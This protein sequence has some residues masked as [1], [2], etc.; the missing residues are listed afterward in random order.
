MC[1][2]SSPIHCNYLRLFLLC[3]CDR[4]APPCLW[5]ISSSPPHSCR[6][7]SQ[8]GNQDSCLF[9]C[10]RLSHSGQSSYISLLYSALGLS[11]TPKKC[12]VTSVNTEFGQWLPMFLMEDWE[13]NRQILWSCNFL[14]LCRKP[15]WKIVRSLKGLIY[16]ERW[17]LWYLLLWDRAISL[18]FCG[19]DQK[20]HPGPE[21]IFPTKVF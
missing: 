18:S 12:R 13:I 17:S 9:S 2:F 7:L 16:E 21:K 11:K 5:S 3:V 8:A 15:G 1:L 14:H 4:L 19:F 10:W 6:T 20:F